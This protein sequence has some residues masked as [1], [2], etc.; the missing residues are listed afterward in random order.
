MD[1]EF[2]LKNTI[3]STLLVF[4]LHWRNNAQSFL[5]WNY[6]K[7]ETEKKIIPIAPFWA[8]SFF[9]RPNLQSPLVQFSEIWPQPSFKTPTSDGRSCNYWKINQKI[10]I[11]IIWLRYVKLN[12]RR[13]RERERDTMRMCLQYTG[14]QLLSWWR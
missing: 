8:M 10:K 12:S 7:N 13:E 14:K 4:F 9:I 5:S 11:V 3:S 6:W 2:G 1:Y